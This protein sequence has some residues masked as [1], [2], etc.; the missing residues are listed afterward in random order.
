MGDIANKD[1][2]SK[3]A[4]IARQALAAGDVDKAERFANKA[5]RLYPQDEVRRSSRLPSTAPTHPLARLL[6]PTTSPNASS[7]S[8][9]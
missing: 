2:S 4:E 5:M 7:L 9:A 3:C 6:R 8:L 1:E